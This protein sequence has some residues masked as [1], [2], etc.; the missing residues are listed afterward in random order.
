LKDKD[1]DNIQ[2]MIKH[3][4][5]MKMLWYLLIIPRIKC[6]FANPNDTKYL[7][8][9][10]NERRCDDMYCHPTD[11]I[12]WKKFDDEILEFGKESRNI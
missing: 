2:E 3:V 10:A 9:H 7:R 4:P 11:F 8:W 6:L 5:P 12:Q 1:E